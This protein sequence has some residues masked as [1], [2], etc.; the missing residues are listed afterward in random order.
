MCSHL[1]QKFLFYDGAKLFGL[2]TLLSKISSFPLL[3]HIYFIAKPEIE[4][5]I[6]IFYDSYFI[7][8]IIERLKRIRDG[9]NISN[10]V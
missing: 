10:F 6:Y 8:V 2:K 9:E 7:K 1:E 5:K 4:D 3:K